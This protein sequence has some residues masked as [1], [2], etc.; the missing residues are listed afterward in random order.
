MSIIYHQSDCN[1]FNDIIESGFILPSVKTKNINQSPY[2]ILPYIYFSTLPKTVKFQNCLSP[3][4]FVFDSDIL[5][6]HVFYTRDMHGGSNLTTAKKYPK[7]YKYIDK[8]LYDLFKKSYET[9]SYLY[10]TM[11]Y[12]MSAIFQ[13]IFFKG[14]ISLKYCTHIIVPEEYDIKIIMSKYPNITIFRDNS[15]QT[16]IKKG[17]LKDQ[18]IVIH[19]KIRKQL[20]NKKY[21]NIK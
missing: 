13:E 7:N 17:L 11:R 5:K 15:P 1:Y 14:K 6:N 3:C 4:T 10:G 12:S 2:G 18:F 19:S 21:K 16:R 9:A 8:I 20:A